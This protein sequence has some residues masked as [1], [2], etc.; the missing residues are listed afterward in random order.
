MI[1]FVKQAFNIT[2][3][4]NF[5]ILCGILSPKNEHITASMPNITVEKEITVQQYK[6]LKKLYFSKHSFSYLILYFTAVETMK[7]ALT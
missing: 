2:F 4:H 1:T 6:L 7:S 3:A 5:A